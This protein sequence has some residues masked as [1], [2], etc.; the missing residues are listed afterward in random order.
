MDQF[1]TRIKV[2]LLRGEWK[3]LPN[4]PRRSDGSVHEY[5]PPEQV[6]SEMDRLIEMYLLHENRN[7]PPEV[8]AAW[9]HHRFT[10]IHPFQDGNGRIAR[11]LATLIFLRAGWFPLVVRSA[12]RQKYI[13][14][15]E[16]ADAGDLQP[17]TSE[18]AALAKQSFVNALGVS[19][20]VL[21][22][23]AGVAEI[24]EAAAN[25][26]R[27]RKREQERRMARVFDYADD[28][29]AFGEGRLDRVREIV[30]STLTSVNQEYRSW[31]DCASN[32]SL[33]DHFFRYQ[34]VMAAKQQHY[35]ANTQTY[36]AWVRLAIRTD[37]RTD[38]ILS[39]HCLGQ[40]FSGIMVCSAL[41][42]SREETEQ[43]ASE[44]VDVAALGD[45]PFQFN[46][47]DQV[48]ILKT[49]FDQWLEEVL[50]VGLDR[51]RRSL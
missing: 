4:N 29:V 22:D 40:Q 21:H 31:V 39:F 43:S 18:I 6:A 16:Y 28:L 35:F 37:L 51:W 42:Y 27:E 49:R 41:S 34:I 50:P 30:T 5:C 47:N 19:R 8:E 46:Y 20:E 44:I 1:G 23:K 11:A 48:A 12:N 38:I 25:V 2:E 15:L 13:S 10:E 26:L 9:L 36:R 32:D 17:L 33:R 14:A 7:V 24:V 3:R 45:S